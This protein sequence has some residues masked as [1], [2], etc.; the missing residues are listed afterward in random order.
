MWGPSKGTEYNL[1]NRAQFCFIAGQAL[2]RQSAGQTN[3]DSN[4]V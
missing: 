2:R 3:N 1:V 4:L